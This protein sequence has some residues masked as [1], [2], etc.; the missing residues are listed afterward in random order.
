MVSTLN[1][2]RSFDRFEV[3]RGVGAVGREWR[4]FRNGARADGLRL[5]HW[6]KAGTDPDAGL[7]N[8]QDPVFWFLTP[9]P[10]IPF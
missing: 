8:P 5:S 6:V 7:W 2:I 4:E 9:L 1:V 10:R 3:L